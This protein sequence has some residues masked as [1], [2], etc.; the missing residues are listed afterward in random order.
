MK[1][2]RLQIALAAGVCLLCFALGRFSANSPPNTKVAEN[3]KIDD[4]IN[5]D[6]HKTTVTVTK[7]E[8]SGEKITTTTTNVDTV[9]AENKKT[10][11]I[12]T[13]EVT[14][15]KQPS[16]NLS[17]LVGVDIKDFT[18]VYGA[19]AQ[20]RFLGPITLGLFGLTNGNFGVS[21][22]LEF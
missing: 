3:T 7:Q 9:V 2:S 12:T 17:A 5:K 16:I 15:N 21:V 10:D 13:T 19:S 4:Q 1:L 11:S 20:K 8:P 14:Q 22:G 18:P 6:T